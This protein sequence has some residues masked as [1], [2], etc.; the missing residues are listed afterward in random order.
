MLLLWDASVAFPALV[1]VA[2]R[3]LTRAIGG[4]ESL[5]AAVLQVSVAS[6]Y[7]YKYKITFSQSLLVWNDLMLVMGSKQGDLEKKF[8]TRADTIARLT[9]VHHGGTCFAGMSI[10]I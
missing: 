8:N 1:E 5:L 10:K 6:L 2:A 9:L 7:K 3:R 4:G